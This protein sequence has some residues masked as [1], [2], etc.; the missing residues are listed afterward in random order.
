[1]NSAT[2]TNIRAAIFL[3]LVP[4]VRLLI[5]SGISH[6]EIS[7]ILK[8]AFVHVATE[9]H[10]V[11]GRPTSITRVAAMTG[12]TRKEVSRLR[13]ELA[14]KVISSDAKLSVPA[15][16]LHVW[17]TCPDYLSSDG[18]PDDL[19]FSDR[20]PSFSD[21]VRQ[22]SADSSPHAIKSELLRIGAI[23]ELSEGRLRCNQRHFVPIGLEEV[24]AEGLLSGIRLVADT[25]A[26][27]FDSA[28]RGLAKKRFQRVV[29]AECPQGAPKSV[30]QAHIEKSLT[31]ISEQLDDELSSF[32]KG[33]C[34]ESSEKK[35]PGSSEQKQTVGVGFYYFEL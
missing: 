10:G 14:L 25:V 17:H 31:A 3:A 33:L 6:R 13:D 20:V 22:V 34:F 30:I 1:M 26:F 19:D 16:V 18:K 2:D 28:K 21:L 15:S 7:H 24:V 35:N 4:V 9:E 23:S 27:N 5:G 32:L 11:R 29:E 8:L 12:L